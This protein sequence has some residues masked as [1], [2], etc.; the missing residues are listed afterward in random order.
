[1]FCPYH[2]VTPPRPCWHYRTHHSFP[3]QKKCVGGWLASAMMERAG[4]ACSPPGRSSA[5]R[6]VAHRWSNGGRD[7][8][9][10]PRF[11]GV[12][13]GGQGD[14]A[15][16]GWRP[17]AAAGVA[18]FGTAR[19]RHGVAVPAVAFAPDGKSLASGGSEGTVSVWDR[20]TG[21]E[22]R[23][24]AVEDQ[25]TVNWV[26]FTPDG[27]GLLAAGAGPGP[28]LGPCHRQAAARV[29]RPRAAPVPRLRR[30]VAGRQDVGPAR[31]RQDPDLVGGRHGPADAG[32][33][34][35]QTFGC[36]GLAFAP[37]GQ[38]LAAVSGTGKGICLW[39]VA[40]GKAVRLFPTGEDI[41]A[42]AFSPR[43]DLLAS[44]E[45]DTVCLHRWPRAG[46]CGGPKASGA[47]GAN[48]CRGWPSH[49]TA[50]C[51]PRP[52]GTGRCGCGPR[53]PAR[54]CC[55]A[56]T[57]WPWPSPFRRTAS[58]WPRAVGMRAVRLWEVPGGE[59]RLAG[60]GHQAWAQEVLFHP[61]GK[62]LLSAGADNTVRFWDLESGREVRRLDAWYGRI[63]V[64]PD[65]RTLATAGDGRAAWR[66]W[67]LKTGRL[68]R[69]QDN[70]RP[71]QRL[72]GVRP[73]RQT[74]RHGE[75]RPGAPLERGRRSGGPRL[76]PRS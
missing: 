3:P 75:R 39:G 52:D 68:S 60:A 55:A 18:R 66:L 61:D 36:F 16:R 38:T 6:K 22:L 49:R 10:Q 76:F 15:R 25:G 44:A 21:K 47:A 65:G 26:A 42:L 74:V 70:P 62:S 8:H 9:S 64:S 11:P 45:R 63:A 30:P 17:A 34:T 24:F 32:T 54:N 48:G 56:S 14:P 37:D 73:G 50:S 72:P 5:W 67:D 4:A 1:M 13:P 35:G 71:R 20:A 46:N 51:W 27:K 31:A 33:V 69:E 57:G 12:R 40:A 59:E 28:S 58:C 53:T 23:R 29:R 19:L 41:Y 43:G 7:R 2:G